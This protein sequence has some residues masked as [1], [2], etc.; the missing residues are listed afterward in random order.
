MPQGEVC[1]VKGRRCG[2]YYESQNNYT[3]GVTKLK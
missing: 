3:Y 1:A 2:K